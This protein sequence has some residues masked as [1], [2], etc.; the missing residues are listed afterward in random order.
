MVAQHAP[1]VP[2]VEKPFHRVEA[3]I[4]AGGIGERRGE[5][6]RKFP[7]AR[8]RDRPVDGR[9]QRAFG[10]AGERAHQFE[11]GAGRRVDRHG[12]GDRDA[13]G[14]FQRR[15]AAHLCQ[16]HIVDQ[17]AHG[18]D[19]GAGELAEAFQ[20]ADIQMIFQAPFGLRAVEA[21]G[22]QR[23]H[24]AARVKRS[25][26]LIGFQQV[27]RHEQFAGPEAGKL[28]AQRGRIEGRHGKVAGRD[29]DPGKAV[30]GFRADAGDGSEIIMHARRQQRVFG[31]RAGG[32][33]T[34]HLAADHGFG[35]AFLCFGGVFRLLADGDL[36]A[37]A[38]QPLQIGVMAVHRHAAHRDVLAQMLAALGQRDIERP[39]RR[40]GI[41][42]EQLVEIPHPVEQKRAGMARLDLQIL[43]HHRR[44]ARIGL[45]GWPGGLFFGG[46]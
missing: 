28:C 19:L 21:G 18:R 17:R 43:R 6:R 9:H 45:A 38:D 32:D 2:R 39:C 40:H 16:L 7:R 22:G 11:I 4:D 41:V 26:Q 14:R 8:R 5:T 20:R 46:L 30:I 36:E 25:F 24:R 29:I 35:A 13:P 33:E 15:Q 1:R 23:R 3:G 10:L 44:H 37:L 31:Q 27:F 42:E 34:D 12:V